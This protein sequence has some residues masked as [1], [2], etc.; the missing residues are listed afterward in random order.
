MFLEASY[1]L[2]RQSAVSSSFQCDIYKLPALHN[3]KV[4]F[5][6]MRAVPAMGRFCVPAGPA[7]AAGLGGG[8]A[9]SAV[10]GAGRQRQRARGQLRPVVTRH[11]CA[12]HLQGLH[13]A[14]CLGGCLYRAPCAC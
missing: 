12:R 14:P 2:A 1:I 13:L 9:A 6:T 10:P 11:R 5:A 4:V 8:V 3:G 7:A